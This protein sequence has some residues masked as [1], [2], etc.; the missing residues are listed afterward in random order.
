MG[1]V[2]KFSCSELTITKMFF[3]TNYCKDGAFYRL[4]KYCPVDCT[5]CFTRAGVLSV[6]Y[7]RLVRVSLVWRDTFLIFAN[8]LDII[9]TFWWQKLNPKLNY[10]FIFVL[11]GFGGKEMC[12]T[13]TNW[14]ELDTDIVRTLYTENPPSGLH[15]RVVQIWAFFSPWR[16]WRHLHLGLG[17]WFQAKK[18]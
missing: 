18:F 7:P 16:R 15:S 13:I 10:C 11:C 3:Y 1:G 5:Q 2:E 6:L 8:D 12:C 17:I 14:L 9:L 4:Q